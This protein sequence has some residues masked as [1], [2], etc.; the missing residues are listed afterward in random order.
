MGCAICYNASVNDKELYLEEQISEK[1]QNWAR[2]G[3]I[4]GMVLFPFIG[5]ADYFI[6]PENFS[7]FFKYRLAITAVFLFFLFLNSLKRAKNYQYA[8]IYII[9]VLS[10]I[11]IEMMILS[12]GGH[13]S[14]YYAGMNL[15]IIVALGL[16][17]FSG[18]LS[19]SAAVSIYAIYLLP[20]FAFDTIS[21]PT[22]FLA[23]NVF[24]ISTYVIGMTWRIISQKTML[25]ELS[26]QYDLAR[27]KEQVMQYSTKLEDLIAERTREL[28]KS[29]QW[30]RALFENATDGIVVLDR[31]CIII[32][33]N[34]KACEMHGFTREALVGAHIG[35]LEADGVRQKEARS[36][37]GIATGESLV[38]ETAHRKKDGTP[39]HLEISS[40]SIAIGNDL[41]IQS[42]YRDVTEKKKLREHL[43]QSQKMES[44]GVLAGGMAHDFNNI[45]TAILGH[46]EIVRHDG[47][48]DARA[49]KSLTVIETASRRAGQMISKLLGFARKSDYEI[50]PV[51]LN[52]VVYDS[53]KLLE[54]VIDKKISMTV[55]LAQSLPSISADANQMEQI[56]MNLIVNARDAM[57][58]GGHIVIKTIAREAA[59]DRLLDIPPYVLPGPYVQLSVTDNGTGIPKHLLN[60]IFEPFFTT[61]ERGKGTG[62]GLSMVYGAIKG[63][64]GYIWAE[65]EV[66]AGSVFTVLLPSSPST[67]KTASKKLLPIANGTETVLI[68]DDEEDILSAVKNTL[69]LHGYKAI[70]AANSADA[71]DICRRI[72]GEIALVITDI[73]MPHM[74]G[75]ELIKQIKTISCGIRILAISGYTKHVA[76]KDEIR[77]LDGFM[78][79]PFEPGDLLF[80]VRRILDAKAR[81]ILDVSPHE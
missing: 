15:L 35:L 51:N 49:L 37:A 53:V 2:T 12:F 34:D 55:E 74:D 54:R 39:L 76:E 57:P 16:I 56:I 44:I 36:V 10:A 1:I 67:A 19:L 80:S 29:E 28:Q 79:K 61:K 26:L 22:V 47:G 6:T 33:A 25:N 9:M 50:V 73:V 11:T 17:P 68:V 65:S 71:L 32:N 20:I 72:S 78:Q 63:H 43:F 75:K 4:L 81:N 23:N 7:T 8:L 58:N 38:F 77:H 30:H 69:D 5:I 62:L 45:L 24:I 14:P 46:T 59:A 21:Q 27:G 66:G 13:A 31:K 3:L 60:T 70:V 52:D 40:K 42:F 18:V 48:L 64:K 41:F